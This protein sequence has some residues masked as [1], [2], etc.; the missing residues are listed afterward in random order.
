[1][2]TILP[3]GTMDPTLE[4]SFEIQ[5]VLPNGAYY[6]MD[7][8]GQSHIWPTNGNFEWCDNNSTYEAKKEN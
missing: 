1:M 4:G 7:M 8:D 5:T 2:K 6:L 3:L